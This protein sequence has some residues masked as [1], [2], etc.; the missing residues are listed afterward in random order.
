MKGKHAIAGPALVLLSLALAWPDDA[1]TSSP[2]GLLPQ[3]APAFS[4]RDTNGKLVTLDE[5]RGK[6]VLLNFWGTWCPP[7]KAEIPAFER[8]AVEHRENLK[9]VGAA[10][11]SSEAKVLQFCTDF[12]INYPVFMGSYELMEEYG[13]VSAIPTTFIIDKKGRIIDKVIGSRSQAQYEEMLQP[14]LNDWSR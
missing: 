13:K 12:R 8:M 1:V 5:Y 7:C 6:V 3:P 14:L 10:V 2:R 11:F 4:E 9:I